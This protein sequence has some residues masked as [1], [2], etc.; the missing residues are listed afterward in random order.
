MTESGEGAGPGTRVAVTDRGSLWRAADGLIVRLIDPRFCDTR[1]QQALAQLREVQRPSMAPVSGEGWQG[2]HFS[3]EYRVDTEWETLD[4][5]L[6]R[7]HW[8]A[9]LGVIRQICDVLPAWSNSPVHP[10]GINGRS[11]IMQRMAGRWFPWL[12]P[13]PPVEY[14]SPLDLAGCERPV[15]A[16]LAPEI[17]RGAE[18]NYAAA[19]SY[20]LGSLVL[21]AMAPRAG[22][23]ADE[24]ALEMQARNLLAAATPESSEIEPQLRGV[25]AVR[26]VFRT[27]SRYAQTAVLARPADAAD[28]RTACNDAIAATDPVALARRQAAGRELREALR[29][30]EWGFATSGESADGR[31]LAADIC[32]QMEEFDSAAAHIE[33]ALALGPAPISALLR[34]GDLHWRA[35]RVLPPLTQGEADEAGDALLRDLEIAK[36][37]GGQPR[38][39]EPYLRAAAVYRRRGDTA[40]EAQE[41]YAAAEAAPAD[42]EALHRYGDCLR[43]LGSEDVPAVVDEAMR[44]IERMAACE[45]MPDKEAETWRELFRSL[46]SRS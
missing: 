43:R 40:G 25:D 17:V 4:E 32:E 38:A 34:L 19:D 39:A 37:V 27:A 12:L 21:Q 36:S 45:M 35:Y 5:H 33:K 7:L 46:L 9:R 44:R 10:L 3:I 6:A 20:A 26:Q 42:M 28:L 18:V 30:L 1:F 8:R 14:A 2:V 23:G 16:T 22:G 24:P 13:C 31:L 41:L 29:T 15:L 11:I